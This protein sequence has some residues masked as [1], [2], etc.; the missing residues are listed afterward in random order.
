[1]GRSERRLNSFREKERYSAST[2][3]S[4]IKSERADYSF[5]HIQRAET[6]ELRYVSAGSEV[7]RASV[8][9]SERFLKSFG[10]GKAKDTRAGTS[11]RVKAH[12]G[13]SVPRSP[14]SEVGNKPHTRRASEV[15]QVSCEEEVSASTLKAS[16]VYSDV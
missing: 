3:A 10:G 12:A 4:G 16:G 5:V 14:A 6:I 2:T 11:R 9:S 7:L 13:T 15:P 8:F 1:M